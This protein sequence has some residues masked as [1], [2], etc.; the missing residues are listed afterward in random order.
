MDSIFS[1][2]GVQRVTAVVA[3]QLATDHSVSIVTFDKPADCDTSLYGLGEANINYRFFAY[4]EPGWL[5]LMVCKAFSLAYRKLL[6]QTRLLSD[7]YSKTSFPKE[8]RNALATFL[9]EGHYDCIVG[10]HAPLATRLATMAPQLKGVRLVG[11][12]HNSFE[13]LYGPGSPYVGPELKRHYVDQLMKLDATVVLC[14]HDR[15]QYE[16]Y[17]PRFHPMVVYNPLTLTPGERSTGSSKRFLAIGR[18]SP[19]HKGFDL[20]VEAFALFARGDSEWHLDIVG[21]GSEEAALRQQIA[22]RGMQQRIHLHPFTNH[23]EHYY[24]QAQVYVLSSRWEGFGLVLVE[25]MA[26]GLPVV[27]SD[28]PTSV[29]IMG[30]FGIYFANGDVAGLAQALTKSTHIDWNKKSNEAVALAHRFDTKSIAD[31][32]RHLLTASSPLQGKRP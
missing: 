11:W 31:Q 8:R 2:G 23:I 10:V 4:P 17:E 20:L 16:A 13:A 7:I 28:L 1:F 5:K 29:E 26:H 18:L 19:Q 27:S 3:K 12:V 32:W 25:A 6:P 14:Q 24:T 30:D 21:E 15:Q 9:A 22:D